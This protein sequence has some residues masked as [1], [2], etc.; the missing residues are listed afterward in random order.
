MRIGGPQGSQVGLPCRARLIEAVAAPGE[1]RDAELA[2]DQIGGEAGMAPIAI[3]EGM[4]QHQAMVIARGQLVRRVGLVGQPIIHV[5]QKLPQPGWNVMGQGADIGLDRPQFPGPGS[6]IAEHA[7]MQFSEIVFRGERDPAAHGP[8]AAGK[9]IGL[10]GRVE[11]IAGR[12]PRLPKAT[13]VLWREGCRA[14]WLVE[15][16][17]GDDQSCRSVI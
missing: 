9:D 17:Q 10:L 15:Q 3:G 16:R 12:D 8:G 4:D 7:Q 2:T 1:G 13:L 14:L 6:D 5:I 11:I